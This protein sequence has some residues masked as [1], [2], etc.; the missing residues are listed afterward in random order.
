[1]CLIEII[2]EEPGSLRV[3]V[4]MDHAKDMNLRDMLDEVGLV[5]S[6]YE[7]EMGTK[8]SFNY[9]VR[10]F[11]KK[12]YFN[13]GIEIDQNDHWKHEASTEFDNIQSQDNE[14]FNHKLIRKRS[15]SVSGR[16]K[17]K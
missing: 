12:L 9:D 15:I 17:R 10:H 3:F 1:M 2:I 13:P 11:Y 5:L 16:P 4:F 8:Q 14:D 6:R 7:S